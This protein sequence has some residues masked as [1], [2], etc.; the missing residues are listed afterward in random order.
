MTAALWAQTPPL[1]QK[2]HS[3]KVEVL[4]HH[5]LRLGLYQSSRHKRGAAFPPLTRI[6]HLYREIQNF[7]HSTKTGS[8]EEDRNTVEYIWLDI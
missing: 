4:K 2:A 5:W 8:N 7:F 6:K 3:S 1:L